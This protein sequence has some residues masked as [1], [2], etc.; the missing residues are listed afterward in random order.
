MGQGPQLAWSP[1]LSQPTGEVEGPLL[2]AEGPLEVCTA[3]HR[4]PPPSPFIMRFFGFARAVLLGS[5]GAKPY[6]L[7]GCGWFESLRPSVAM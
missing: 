1:S 4:P 6:R 2:A 7:R 3:A 5:H